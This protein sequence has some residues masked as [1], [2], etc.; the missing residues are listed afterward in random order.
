LSGLWL[1]FHYGLIAGLDIET[2]EEDKRPLKRKQE[3]Q[4]G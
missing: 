1:G 3:Y 2:Q 4:S